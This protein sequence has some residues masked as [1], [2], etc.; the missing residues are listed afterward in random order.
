MDYLNFL[1]GLIRITLQL[2]FP[3]NFF[4]P[5]GVFCNGNP[6]VPI[7][8]LSSK[9]NYW[10]EVVSSYQRLFLNTFVK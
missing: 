1:H 10:D 7:A 2:S 3:F 4:T 8:E 9:S 6:I 5:N